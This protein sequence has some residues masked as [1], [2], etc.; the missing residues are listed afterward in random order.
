M[1]ANDDQSRWTCNTQQIPLRKT[2][3][4]KELTQMEMIKNGIEYKT[5][6]PTHIMLLRFIHL[7]AYVLTFFAVAH[8]SVPARNVV[9]AYAIVLSIF[10]VITIF[11]TSLLCLSTLGIKSCSTESILSFK[12]MYLSYEHTPAFTITGY[13]F[14]AADII[15]ASAFIAIGDWFTGSLILFADI[16]TR[17]SIFTSMCFVKNALESI[18]EFNDLK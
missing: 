6:N 4:R 18:N 12:R 8:D 5:A 7:I 15:A 3:T 10:T 1:L 11:V 16:G 17:F 14:F 13:F 9:L 2:L